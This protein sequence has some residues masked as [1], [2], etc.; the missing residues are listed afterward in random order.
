LG[1]PEVAVPSSVFMRLRA[2]RMGFNPDLYC[3]EGKKPRAAVR[4]RAPIADPTQQQATGILANA[5]PTS[6]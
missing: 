1:S 4:G 5:P 6:L 2:A 3:Q